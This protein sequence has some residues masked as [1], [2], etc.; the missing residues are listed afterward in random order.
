MMIVPN[1]IRFGFEKIRSSWKRKKK[2]H[3]GRGS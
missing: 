3:S 1:R 2:Y